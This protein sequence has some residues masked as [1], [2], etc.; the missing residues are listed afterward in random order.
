MRLLSLLL[1]CVATVGAAE[2]S[3]LGKSGAWNNA[4]NW[5]AGVPQAEV[6]AHIPAGTEVVVSA[7]V[8]ITEIAGDGRI[9]VP[10]GGRL[11]VG[12]SPRWSGR[13]ETN[14]GTVRLEGALGAAGTTTIRL[15]GGLL[16]VAADQPDRL[17]V[18][19]DGGGQV[20]AVGAIRRMGGMTV[21][22][23]SAFGL[24]GTY[25]PGSRREAPVQ[26]DWRIA[27]GG[28]SSRR[29]SQV[30]FPDAGM[31]G[32]E[33]FRH[34]AGIAGQRANWE[35]FSVQWD[36]WIRITTDGTRLATTSDDGSRVWV[37]RNGNGRVD[38]GEWGSNGWGQGQGV[39]VREVQPALTPGT[40]RIRIQYEDGNGGNAMS[41]LWDDS[42]D[43]ASVANWQV[44]PADA[45][46]DQA[47]LE[48]SG[49][50]M[51]LTSA[52]GGIFRWSGPGRLVLAG[53]LRSGANLQV[54]AGSVELPAVAVEQI[55]VE[56]GAGALLALGAGDHVMYSLTGTGTVELAEA[57]VRLAPRDAASAQA[58][59]AFTGHGRLINVGSEALV[60]TSAAPEVTLEPVGAPIVVGGQAILQVP[61]GGPLVARST[62]PGAT[63]GWR[64]VRAHITV[65]PEA[66]GRIGCGA[67]AGDPHGTWYQ[68][69]LPGRLPVGTSEQIIDLDAAATSEPMPGRFD[70]VAAAANARTGL[71]FWSDGGLPVNLVVS[72]TV[73]YL[74]SAEGK[75]ASNPGGLINVFDGGELHTGQRW[76][77][78]FR[79]HPLPADPFDPEAFSAVLTV[80]EPDGQERKCQAFWT[81]PQDLAEGGDREDARRQGP[82][83][84]A[85]RYRPQ[86]PGLHHLRLTARW[87]DGSQAAWDLG[88]RTAMGEVWDK[89]VQ[90]DKQDPRFFQVGGRWWWPVGLN[91]RSP[92]DLR[93]EAELGTTLGWNRGSQWYAERFDQLAVAGADAAEVWLAG[94]NLGLE[95]NA[96]WQ[97]FG[98]VGHY[99][100]QN[101]ARLDAVLDA[102]WTRGIRLKLVIYN[103]G[104]GSQGSDAEWD[105]SPFNVNNG[106][107]L[108]GAAGLFRETRAL[109]A[110][111]RY[112]GYLAAR[113]G[114]HPAVMCWK[115]WSEVQLTEAGD[116]TKDWHRQACASWAEVDPWHH[117]LTTHWAGTWHAVDGDVARLPG[118]DFITIDAYRGGG[119]AAPL[120]AESLLR[121]SWVKGKPVLVS[122]YGGDWS[123]CPEPRMRADHASGA[124]VALVTGHAGSPMLWW[125]EWVAQKGGWAPYGAI[126]RFL[127][128]EDLRGKEAS[129]IAVQLEPSRDLWAR[130]W[131]RPGRLLG[132]VCDLAW[133]TDG[134]AGS[135]RAGITLRVGDQIA[136][137]TMTVTWWDADLGTVGSAENI[138]HSGGPL[139]IAIPT[140]QRHVAFK[141][142]RTDAPR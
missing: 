81:E 99:N 91:L 51:M 92:Y 131:R 89:Y 111:A 62:I 7:P 120:L 18:I 37:D 106:G 98:G 118:L 66:A 11:T 12:D 35:D 38:P 129:S 19:G 141:L 28:Q 84:F 103:H 2:T 101:A 44:V 113:Y 132:Y 130:A 33:V 40:Y 57:S 68:R 53:G 14:G 117:P 72:A 30:S 80:T 134:G 114:D 34:R 56:V 107:F 42:H 86:Q 112:R 60:L 49:A 137:G 93:S 109:A 45:L 78:G 121:P 47:P 76:E 139:R 128:G 133:A 39:T 127:A 16:E 48:L 52:I 140:F 4:T 22:G 32:D 116:A 1:L 17:C 96:N 21:G 9:V 24:I 138:I 46:V 122:E 79:P 31:G 125:H 102:A 94:W 50:G 87:A 15:N 59:L 5:T 43:A 20:R 74:P 126:R 58:G 77:A 115:L 67:W 90:V 6:I 54:V 71:I 123:A 3:W 73:E 27:G 13:I 8:G 136:P 97:G 104:Q 85:V 23:L 105:R 41:L 75:S 61:M 108:S 100:Q 64:R 29:D 110:Q 26:D 95:W 55:R 119:A 83:H 10:P 88:E 135:R 82:G 142:V 25:L 36:G 124:W 65:P 63:V 70:E 69:I